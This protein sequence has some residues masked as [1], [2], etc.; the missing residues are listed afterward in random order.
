M[1]IETELNSAHRSLLVEDVL[2]LSNLSRTDVSQLSLSP[3]SLTE[4]S[5]PN[6]KS[7]PSLRLQQR[8]GRRLCRRRLPEIGASEALSRRRPTPH[9]KPELW[10]PLSNMHSM[11]FE[12]PILALI[13]SYTIFDEAL[14][15]RVSRTEPITSV[16]DLA[17]Q[18]HAIF[19]IKDS[20]KVSNLRL[21]SR[22]RLKGW[23]CCRRLFLLASGHNIEKM[24]EKIDGEIRKTALNTLATTYKSLA[25]IQS[26]K[27]V[28]G[29]GNE[30]WRYVGKLTDAQKSMLDDR[31]K[32]KAR[33]MDKMREGKPGE[34]RAA[35]RRA[36]RDNGC[37]S[38]F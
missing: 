21:Y 12:L 13:L 35:L 9:P 29:V 10:L 25:Y 5:L 26:S 16:H 6:P 17:V 31:F 38:N 3:L 28:T 19:N 30:I 24:R 32:W 36:V 22:S 2:S 11:V 23:S 33:E 14:P 37:V 27:H 34:A 4:I 1:E 7:L 20:N 8:R 15:I 18:S